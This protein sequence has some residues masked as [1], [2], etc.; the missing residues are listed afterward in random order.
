L[1][2]IDIVIKTVTKSKLGEERDYLF[3]TLQ[4][5]NSSSLRESGQELKQKPWRNAAYRWFPWSAQLAFLYN[6]DHAPRGIALT[7]SAHAGVKKSQTCR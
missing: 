7:V 1:L 4:G 3:L 5:N 2:S 6:Q